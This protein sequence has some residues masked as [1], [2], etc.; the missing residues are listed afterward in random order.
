MRGSPATGIDLVPLGERMRMISAFRAAAVALAIL[1][2]QLL[3][4][5]RGGLPFE[6]FA[7]VC[8]AYL[9]VTLALEGLWRRSGRRA[10]WIFGTFAMA[11]GVFLAW[12][13]YGQA[14]LAS[15]LVYLPILQIVTVSLLASFRTGLKLAVFNA[16]VLIAAAYLQEAGIVHA[17]GG[18]PISFGNAAYRQLLVV[19][20]VYVLLALVTTTFAAVNER[21][22]RRRRYD[23]EALA[24]FALDLE[25]VE[26][27]EEVAARL[28]AGVADVYGCEPSLVLRREGD[29]VRVLAARGLDTARAG[30]TLLVDPA[31]A[32]LVT[33]ALQRYGTS[34]LTTSSPTAD[35]VLAPFGAGANLLVTPMRDEHGAVVG[36]LVAQHSARRGSRVERRVVSMVERFASHASLAIANAYLLR[37]VRDL[38]TTDGLTGLPNRRHLDEQLGRACAHIARGQGR[39]PS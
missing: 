17:L 19:A 32:P 7:L 36:A 28:L 35:V 11:D 22:L 5:A 27:P 25:S 15:P 38:A 33:A 34:L 3:P 39:W 31:A 12:V 26:A 30:D 20:V 4:A 29:A 2:W 37:A 16:W 6:T 21:E 23:L 10:T 1:G 13:S 14:G 9:V 18:Q 8:L 24:R